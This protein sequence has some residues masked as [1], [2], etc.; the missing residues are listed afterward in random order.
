[1][2]KELVTQCMDYLKNHEY[3]CL[4][5]TKDLIAWRCKAPHTT[6]YAFDILITRFG[7]AVVGDLGNFTFRVGM[8]YGIP[9]LAGDEI[10]Y[11]ILSKL[12]ENCKVREFNV[13][14]FYQV[15]KEYLTAWIYE[16]LIEEMEEDVETE[17]NKTVEKF[18]KEPNCFKEVISYIEKNSCFFKSDKVNNLLTTI[19]DLDYLDMNSQTIHDWLNENEKAFGMS[20]S[21]EYSFESV[22]ES[23][24]FKLYMINH[25]AKEIMKMKGNI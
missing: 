19:I 9:F 8:D 15:L 2:N 17:I 10:N 24:L 5:Q 4:V 12:D 3:K 25:A 22:D 14:Y 13:K 11:Y 1:M 18:I 7:I 23:T 20:D 21:W 6:I 16:N